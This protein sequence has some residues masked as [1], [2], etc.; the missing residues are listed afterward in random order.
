MN[1]S[2]IIPN[3]NGAGLLKKNLP[4][5]VEAI[6]EYDKGWIEII[7][8]DDASSD[9][10]IEVIQ[11]CISSLSVKN[12]KI[13]TTTNT[14]R[15]KGGFSANV[16]RGVNLSS[17][18]ILVF[19]NSDVVPHKG[20]LLP[21]LS[22]FTDKK[23]FGVGCMDESIENEKIILRGR[24]IGK[25]QRGFLT[26]RLGSV[27]K[28]NTL[29]VSGGSSAF[30]RIIYKEI[31]G[32]NNLYNPFYW[33]DIDLSYRAQKAGYEV[34]FEPKSKVVHEHSKGSIA[35]NYKPFRI[36]KIA[37]RN[38]FFF[39]WI[40]ITD[41]DLMITHILWLPYY[42]LKTLLARDLAF[43]VG[44]FLALKDISKVLIQRKN[45]QKLFVLTDHEVLKQFAE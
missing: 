31:G 8:P 23:V 15:S 24:G 7:I 44:F 12:I 11:E 36:Q 5:V 4:K 42:F 21:L 22:H 38:M 14:D 34:V 39:V 45:A 13:K 18:D 27:D 43:W 28:T 1:I 6:K 16:T 37:Y 26:H 10:S 33:E 29:W 25:W 20:F 35:T 41:F 30:S 9:N 19:L 3:Y 40:N 2:I 32:L 17:G